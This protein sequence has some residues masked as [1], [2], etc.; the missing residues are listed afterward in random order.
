[1]TTI[2]RGGRRLLGRSNALSRGPL[3]LKELRIG[4]RFQCLNQNIPILGPLSILVRQSVLNQDARSDAIVRFG[5][6][7]VQLNFHWQ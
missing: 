4:D 3:C 1:M 2:S 7:I 6:K 5:A